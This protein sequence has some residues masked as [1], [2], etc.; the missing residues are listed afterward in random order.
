MTRPSEQVEAEL[1]GAWPTD[2]VRHITLHHEAADTI[3]AEREARERVE[4][5][6]GADS[7]TVALAQEVLRRAGVGPPADNPEA[8]ND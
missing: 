5:Q 2:A 6:Q 7:A 4:R 3:K 8:D 1:R